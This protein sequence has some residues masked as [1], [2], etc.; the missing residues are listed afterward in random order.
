[1]NN[2]NNMNINIINPSYRGSYNNQI[3]NE[4][5]LINSFNQ[6]NVQRN[7]QTPPKGDK[8]LYNYYFGNGQGGLSSNLPNEMEPIGK[9][10]NFYNKIPTAKGIN[11]INTINDYVN[12]IEQTRNFQPNINQYPFYENQMHLGPTKI[13][14]SNKLPYHPRTNNERDI[15]GKTDGN[16]LSQKH[17]AYSMNTI[18]QGQPPMGRF[19]VLKSID[20]DNIHKVK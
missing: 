10:P 15:Y 19:F 11:P 2:I 6:M 18:P 16:V 13:N 12:P 3:G 9:F 17:S 4:D 1:M 5:D 7:D 8:N 20:E 14:H